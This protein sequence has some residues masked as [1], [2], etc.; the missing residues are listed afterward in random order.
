VKP[1]SYIH[2]CYRF[3]FASSYINLLLSLTSPRFY[4]ALTSIVLAK[5]SVFLL[6]CSGQVHLSISLLHLLKLWDFLIGVTCERG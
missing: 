6:L 1:S 5:N 3:M 4:E 2:C